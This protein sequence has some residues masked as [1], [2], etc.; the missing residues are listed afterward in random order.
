MFLRDAADTIKTSN[1]PCSTV[2]WRRG[3]TAT[4]SVWR[5]RGRRNSP[6]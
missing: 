1:R 4:S 2:P 3:F 6:D 5:R